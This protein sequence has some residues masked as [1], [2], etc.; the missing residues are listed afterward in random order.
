MARIVKLRTKPAAESYVNPV[1]NITETAF[2]AP[3]IKSI[4]IMPQRLLI[5]K[6]NMPKPFFNS[7]PASVLKKE[8]HF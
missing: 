5:T 8:V 2:K 4:K 6:N 7:F 3:L 1:D